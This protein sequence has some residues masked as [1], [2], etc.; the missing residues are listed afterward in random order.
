MALGTC[1]DSFLTPYVE[2]HLYLTIVKTLSTLTLTARRGANI[3][4][5]YWPYG[6]K[7]WYPLMPLHLS[8]QL[9]IGLNTEQNYGRRLRLKACRAQYQA[10][11]DNTKRARHLCEGRQLAGA[12]EFPLEG[13]NWD[14]DRLLHIVVAVSEVAGMDHHN[15]FGCAMEESSQLT[16]GHT[17]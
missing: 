11:V 10:V 2:G 6:H 4:D 17:N 14:L 1:Q 15:R 9:N 8:I 7:T 13:N 3:V 5:I 12:I 16:E